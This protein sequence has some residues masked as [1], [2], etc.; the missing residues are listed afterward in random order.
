MRLKDVPESPAYVV[1]HDAYMKGAMDVWAASS[2]EL[3]ERVVKANQNVLEKSG[4]DDSG[5]WK[6]YEKLPRV[7]VW[8]F[9]GQVLGAL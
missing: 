5:G 8:K 4:A 6:A 9:H 3:A 2:L 7:K 1:F